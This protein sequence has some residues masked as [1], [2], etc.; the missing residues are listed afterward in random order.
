MTYSKHLL[1]SVLLVLAPLASKATTISLVPTASTIEVGESVGV[2]VLISDLD[3]GSSV[4]LGGFQLEMLFAPGALQSTGIVDFGPFLGDPDPLAFETITVVDTT[5]PGTVFLSETSLLLDFELD[6]LQP[7]DFLLA[8][9]YLQGIG[10]GTVAITPF[11]VVLSD[12][13]GITIP[14]PIVQS[15]TITVTSSLGSV[16]VPGSLFLFAAAL[17]RLHVSRLEKRA[18]DNC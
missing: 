4:S 10:T 7:A 12:A 11:D 6:A 3:A 9:A 1:L 15:G 13:T 18:Q 2:D 8:T 5:V 14:N 17:F 16:P